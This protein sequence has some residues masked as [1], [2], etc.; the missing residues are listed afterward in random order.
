[1]GRF[2]RK[3]LRCLSREEISDP[4]AT[5]RETL[6]FRG[7]GRLLMP[8]VRGL[9]W[10]LGCIGLRFGGL[11]RAFFPRDDGKLG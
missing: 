10:S 6:R 11:R 2:A 4:F 7:D 1:M 9:L 5:P 8:R 3:V